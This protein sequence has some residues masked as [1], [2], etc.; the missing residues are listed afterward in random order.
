VA[1]APW[2]TAV[3]QG[4]IAAGGVTAVVGMVRV[5]AERRKLGAEANAHTA[6]AAETL[7]GTAVALLAP[8]RDEIAA[9]S[10]A[11]TAADDRVA[12]LRL[13]ILTRDARLFDL[14]ERLAVAESR[15]ARLSA[16]LADARAAITD[17]DNPEA[18]S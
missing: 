16:D 4:L 8:L 11:L 14:A 7:T 17:R 10:A 3:I 1:A 6:T 13:E 2:M 18:P 9:Q 15:I 12:A 5:V